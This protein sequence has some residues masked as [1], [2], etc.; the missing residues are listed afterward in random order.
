MKLVKTKLLPELGVSHNEDIKKKVF[1]GNNIVPQL[2]M[3]GS[4]IF[5][6]G[7]FV[8]RHKHDSMYEVFFIQYGKVDF[9]VDG[10]KH[11][12]E[13]GDCMTIEQGEW[14]EQINCYDENVSWLYFG[15]ATD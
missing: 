7:Q 9:V 3:F 12:L 14:H 10:V 2:M 1:L 6:P 8:E 13:S 4:A 11:T 5:K 15:V